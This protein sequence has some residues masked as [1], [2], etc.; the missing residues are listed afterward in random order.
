MCIRDRPAGNLQATCRQAAGNLQAT[1]GQPAGN[2]RATCRQRAGN[3]QAVSYP[4]LRAH[5]TSAHL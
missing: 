5:E 1:C 4:H 2:L 3:L